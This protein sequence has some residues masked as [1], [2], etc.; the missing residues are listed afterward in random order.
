MTTESLKKLMDLT[1]IAVKK[2]DTNYRRSIGDE[3]RRAIF[4]RYEFEVICNINIDR[5]I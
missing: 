5:L 2:M 1:G 4:L 3:E